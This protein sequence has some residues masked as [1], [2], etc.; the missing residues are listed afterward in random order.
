[1]GKRVAADLHVH[2]AL[3]PCGSEEMRPP[4]VLLTAERRGIGVLGVVDHSTAR[5]AWAFL[6]AAEAFDVRVFAGLEVESAEG[7]HVLALFDTLEAVAAMDD[8][9]A[10]RLPGLPNRADL[11]GEQLLVDEMGTAVGEDGRLLLTATDLTVEEIAVATAEA[12]GMSI[13]AH[14]DRSANG[15]LPTLGFVPTDLRVE[16]LE[17]SR[18]L[19]PAEARR[20]WPELA[21][22]PLVASSDAHYLD[23]VGGAVTWIS[24]GL[25]AAEVPAAEWARLLAEELRDED[26]A[27]ED[28]SE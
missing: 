5:N 28:G 21:G 19:A 10:A 7:V 13:P 20:R 8:L 6:G 14:V 1:M 3:S 2:S 17:V 22:W 16:V 9:V 12:G 15:L 26:Q 25:A 24:E 4:A 18:P 23:D 27:A 11:F